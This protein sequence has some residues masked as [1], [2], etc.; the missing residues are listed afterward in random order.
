MLVASGTAIASH[1]AFLDHELRKS[2]VRSLTRDPIRV[3]YVVVWSVRSLGDVNFALN[4]FRRYEKILN[5]HHSDNLCN[6]FEFIIYVTRDERGTA[7][8]NS[9]F[10]H[11]KISRLFG[12]D[13]RITFSREQ[14]H[15]ESASIYLHHDRRKIC[16]T[17]FGSRPDV[18][19]LER[20]FIRDSA[21]EIRL[22][23]ASF[24]SS[25]VKKWRRVARRNG[26][27]DVYY[28]TYD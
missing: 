16:T 6:R 8:N 1:L 20:R 14:V 24:Q 21:S 7:E 9:R 23:V 2:Y 15:S 11:E 13:N 25:Y 5:D 17:I 27:T 3:E 4:Y 22:R 18:A 12:F 10:V 26:L 28:E 19:Y